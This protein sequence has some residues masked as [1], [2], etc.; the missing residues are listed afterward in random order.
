MSI[1]LKDEPADAFSVDAWRAWRREVE[2]LPDTVENRA[3]LLA[4]ADAWIADLT[5]VA[6]AEQKTA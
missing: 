2:A 6:S 3:Q 5:A 1:L 4:E